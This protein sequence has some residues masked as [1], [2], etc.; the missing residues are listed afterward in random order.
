[1]GLHAGF[2]ARV[3]PFDGAAAK[4]NSHWDTFQS[5]ATRGL[6]LKQSS[7]NRD[8]TNRSLMKKNP[9]FKLGGRIPMSIWYK[10]GANLHSEQTS[11]FLKTKF[12]Q[13][14]ALFVKKFVIGFVS[15]NVWLLSME[16]CLC[17]SILDSFCSIFITGS[18]VV[19]PKMLGE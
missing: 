2:R 18:C 19:L 6:A 4:E 14:F 8:C 15:W 16:L 7:G 9:R 11:V 3:L 1:M 12:L 5:I 13:V 17:K 10:L